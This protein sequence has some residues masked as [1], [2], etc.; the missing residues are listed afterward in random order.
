M[1][2]LF[3]DIECIH[4]AKRDYI[5][6]FGYVICDEKFN[7]IEQRDILINPD[8][9]FQVSTGIKIHYHWN[10]I[11]SQPTFIY[12]YETIKQLL[13]SPSH[14][15]FGHAIDND[16]R[17]LF[18]EC[19]QYSLPGFNFEFIDTQVIFDHFHQCESRSSIAKILNYYQ[20]NPEALHRSDI[21]ALYNMTYVKKLCDEQGIPLIELVNKPNIIKGKSE[22]LNFD[23]CL[24]MDW[25]YEPTQID[26]KESL[27]SLIKVNSFEKISTT[28]EGKSFVINTKI[29][30]DNLDVGVYLIKI[31]VENGGIFQ[32]TN[33]NPT[34]FIYSENDCK[35]QIKF[36]SNVLW[37]GSFWSVEELFKEL[38]IIHGNLIDNSRGLFK[39]LIFDKNKDNSMVGS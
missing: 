19:Q 38:G 27:I 34:I 15:I 33:P 25:I 17:F 20:I 32:Q 16:I 28:L 37:E 29:L 36:Q 18:Q 23:R 5:F 13:E 2:Y 7:I 35:R 12:F 6:S 22:G 9:N 39:S 11:K 24:L 10:A 31:I 30:Y 26:N 21:D 8:V 1:A 14:H 4:V 3:F